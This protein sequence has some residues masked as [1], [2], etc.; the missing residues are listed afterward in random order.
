MITIWPTDISYIVICFLAIIFSLRE[1]RLFCSTVWLKACCMFETVKSRYTFCNDCN[2]SWKRTPKHVYHT[3]FFRKF[4]AM[5]FYFPFSLQF[6]NDL[7]VCVCFNDIL[8]KNLVS[9]KKIEASE[10]KL[11]IRRQKGICHVLK[12]WG[13]KFK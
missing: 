9:A 10:L 1:S 7:C 11:N 12:I 13:E 6:S 3:N 5:I 4:Y 8:G 2:V